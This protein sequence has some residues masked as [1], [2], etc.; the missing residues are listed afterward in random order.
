MDRRPAECELS[1]E[2]RDLSV[3][4]CRPRAEALVPDRVLLFPMRWRHIDGNHGSMRDVPPVARDDDKWHV[5][6]LD[7][8]GDGA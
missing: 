6:P 8:P 7:E 5:Q 3:Q 4:M 2:R 1:R